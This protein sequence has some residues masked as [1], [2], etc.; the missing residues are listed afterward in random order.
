MNETLIHDQALEIETRT[1]NIS[2][3]VYNGGIHSKKKE[4]RSKDELMK[5]RN[6]EGRKMKLYFLII[7]ITIK[8]IKTSNRISWYA[9]SGHFSCPYH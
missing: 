4:K 7:T 2:E 6:E 5:Q 1:R 9:R 3:G 8:H